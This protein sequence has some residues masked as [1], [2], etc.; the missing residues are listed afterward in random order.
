MDLSSIIP[1]IPLLLGPV[2]SMLA[3]LFK[4]LPASPFTPKSASAVRLVVAVLAI[5]LNVF[6]DWATGVPQAID[7]TMVLQG[8]LD[9]AQTYIAAVA[10][11]DHLPKRTSDAK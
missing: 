2:A 4:L 10:T 11:H 9:A 1:L 7:F 5:L 3:Q 8:F 6:V